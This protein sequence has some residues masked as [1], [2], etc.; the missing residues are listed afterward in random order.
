MESESGFPA[1]TE[2]F[3]VKQTLFTP[4]YLFWDSTSNDSFKSWLLK[5]VIHSEKQILNKITGGFG[6]LTAMTSEQEK[7]YT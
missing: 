7:I 3:N 4:N 1:I 6:V 2:N 5:W